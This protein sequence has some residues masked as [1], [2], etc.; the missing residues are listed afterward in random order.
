VRRRPIGR[1]VGAEDGVHGGPAK[2]VG[3]AGWGEGDDGDVGTEF[4]G[5]VAGHSE[6]GGAALPEAAPALFLVV[7]AAELPH[8]RVES[9]E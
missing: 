7:D 8:H 1:E 6:E 2:S 4:L 5:D 9:A 3:L